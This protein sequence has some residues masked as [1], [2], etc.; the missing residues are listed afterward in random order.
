[1]SNIVNAP[2]KQTSLNIT[3]E[4]YIKAIF[5][6]RESDF[7]ITENI[8]FFGTNGSWIVWGTGENGIELILYTEKQ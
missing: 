2:W 6:G 4:F 8:Y 5:F 7:K 3:L 1:M